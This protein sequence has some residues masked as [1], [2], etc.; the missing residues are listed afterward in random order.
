MKAFN[1]KSSKLSLAGTT[2]PVIFLGRKTSEVIVQVAEGDFL[3]EGLTITGKPCLVPATGSPAQKSQGYILRIDTSTINSLGSMSL[4]NYGDNYV[5]FHTDATVTPSVVAKTTS[6]LEDDKKQQWDDMILVVADN[7][8]LKI[9]PFNQDYQR[10]LWLGYGGIVE[11]TRQKA[12]LASDVVPAFPRD[13][14]ADKFR[15]V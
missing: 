4:K 11:L 7:T 8:L 3:E 12:G 9:T 2:V 15:R 10:Y 1:L 5:A 13:L 6:F 14:S